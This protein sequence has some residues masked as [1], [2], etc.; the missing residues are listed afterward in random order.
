MD[1]RLLCV[2][3]VY[4]AVLGQYLAVPDLSELGASWHKM[5][6]LMDWHQGGKQSPF[7]DKF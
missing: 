6:A 7:Y 5:Y 4:F 1:P 3:C 2:A